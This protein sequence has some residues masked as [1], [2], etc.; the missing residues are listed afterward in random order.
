MHIKPNFAPPIRALIVSLL[1][2][3]P[4]SAAK[5]EGEFLPAVVSFTKTDYGADGQNWAIVEST[6]G[7]ILVGNHR[8]LLIFDGYT[9]ECMSLPGGQPVRAVEVMGDRVYVGAYHEFGYWQRNDSGVLEYTS[10][11]EAF[12]G[13]SMK[14]D[15]IWHIAAWGDKVLFQAFHAWYIYDGTDVRMVRSVPLMQ[16]LHVTDSGQ[17]LVFV[18]GQGLAEAQPEEGSFNFLEGVP[19]ESPVVAVLPIEDGSSWIVTSG[20]GLFRWEGG[21]FTP[22][23]TQ[24]DALLRN[25]SPSSAVLDPVT[26]VLVVGTRTGGILTFSSDGTFRFHLDSENILPGDIIHAMNYDSIGNLW[27]AMGNGLSMLQANAPIRH[28]PSLHP[29]VGDIYASAYQ[30]PYLYLGTSQGL[31]RGRL[32]EDFSRLTDLQMVPE[33]HGHVLDLF[34]VDGQLFCG[35]NGETFELFPDR[36]R[37]VWWVTGGSAMDKGRIHDQEVLVQGTYSSLC[38]YFRKNGR[39]VFAHEVEGFSQPVRSLRIDNFG[40]IWAAHQHG[41]LFAVRLSED[42]RSVSKQSHFASLDGS[43][44]SR[45]VQVCRFKDRVVFTAGESGF[46]TYSDLEDKLHPFHPLDHFSHINNIV[47]VGPNRYMF[48]NRSGAML[49]HAPS[50]DSLTVLERIPSAQM[51]GIPV[52]GTPKVFPLSSDHFIFPMENALAIY[53]T[54]NHLNRAGR[55]RLYLARVKAVNYD[56]QEEQILPLTLQRPRLSYCFRNV[57]LSF[58]YAGSSSEASPRFRYRVRGLGDSWHWVQG[59]PRVL[60]DYLPSG[61]FNLEF[62]ALS[63]DGTLLSAVSYPFSVKPP[64]Y[65]S[66]WAFV[67]YVLLGLLAVFMGFWYMR[68][69]MILR[70]A[71]QEKERMQEEMKQ[72][73]KELSSYTWN[74]SHHNEGLIRIRDIVTEKKLR[75]G[76]DFPDKDYRQVIAVIEEQLASGGDWNLFVANFNMLHENFF[77][78]LKA[79]CPDLTENDLRVCAYIRMNVSSKEMAN[80]LNIT[81]KGVEA[82]RTRVRKKLMLPA[83]Q[84]LSTYLMSL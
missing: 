44:A 54:R 8:G 82:A 5:A 46:Y 25:A 53:D 30:A 1:L 37:S 50:S 69:Q 74:A 33:I 9:W 23:K 63:V 77:T 28:I 19:F 71:L 42:L 79:R 20:D 60:L 32:S 29:Y 70:N 62:E 48:L 61:H 72:K 15:E 12:S 52:D 57:E 13:E 3:L 78:S 41:G 17:V 59:A 39:W 35:T 80:L 10:L 56:K 49:V 45:L 21:R 11:A 6:P 83:D 36:V 58:R 67:L 75:L 22:V 24:A 4:L 31:F 84:P 40:T 18:Q 81:L 55:P 47:P 68:H 51:G 7:E 64:F 14:N 43:A 16:S 34:S 2:T 26:G 66:W 65:R 27:V 73:V 38:I 76:K